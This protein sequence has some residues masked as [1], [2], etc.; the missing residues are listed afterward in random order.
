[1]DL[2]IDSVQRGNNGDP[3]DQRTIDFCYDESMF[4]PMCD[5]CIYITK[6][7]RHTFDVLKKLNQQ[8]INL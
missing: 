1:M 2:Q 3:E 4:I 5:V 6:G 7:E 8:L